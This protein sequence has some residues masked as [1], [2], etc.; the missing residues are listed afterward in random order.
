MIDIYQMKPYFEEQH[1]NFV[2]RTFSADINEEELKWHRD[3]EDRVVIPIGETD[4][5]FQREDSLP[6]D[7]GGRI[8]IQAGEWHRLIK[9]TGDLIVKI[10]KL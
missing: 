5:K 2:M 4:W 3:I 10:Y 9:G 1:K 7:F 8:F 6:V